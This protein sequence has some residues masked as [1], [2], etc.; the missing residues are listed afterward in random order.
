MNIFIWV[1][2]IYLMG[3]WPTYWMLVKM[4][5]DDQFELATSDDFK[6]FW[7]CLLAWPLMGSL[8]LLGMAIQG[9]A[10]IFD[11]GKRFTQKLVEAERANKGKRKLITD[12]EIRAEIRKQHEKV[13]YM[14]SG[15]GS[16]RDVTKL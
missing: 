7:V 1:V 9:V 6:F 4:A 14:R 3:L 15:T 2:M 16:K 8:L 11:H 13:Q 12:E 5:A 10:A